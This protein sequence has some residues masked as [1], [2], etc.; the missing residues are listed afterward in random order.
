[1]N[2]TT[3]IIIN[4][5]IRLRIKSMTGTHNPEAKNI[6]EA[7]GFALKDSVAIAKLKIKHL[8]PI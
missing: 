8:N 5:L 1:M 4:N 6:I 2:A 3:A 7:A